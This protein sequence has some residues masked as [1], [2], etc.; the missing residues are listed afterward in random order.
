MD[1][2]VEKSVLRS[3]VE[4]L[5]HRGPDEAGI[6]V[7]PEVGLGNARLGIIDIRGGRQPTRLGIDLAEP[8]TKAVVTLT[9][10]PAGR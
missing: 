2:P 7:R 4:A 6:L 10:V 5:Y 1:R 9:I 3:M 8:V